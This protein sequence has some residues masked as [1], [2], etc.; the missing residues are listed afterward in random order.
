MTRKLD[1]AELP[2]WPRG[3][4]LAQAAAYVGLCQAKYKQAVKAGRYP[5][6]TMEGN[7][8]DR[9]LLDEYASARRTGQAGLTGGPLG[10]T[11]TPMDLDQ[12]FGLGRVGDQVSQ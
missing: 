1:L 3:L 10:I 4:T 7:R 6:P 9:D 12:E 11:L 2:G 5:E 8:Y